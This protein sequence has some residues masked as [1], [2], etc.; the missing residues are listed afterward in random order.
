MT[1]IEDWEV[2]LVDLGSRLRI[3]RQRRRWSQRSF[4]E[5]MGVSKQ[6]VERLERGDP[7]IRLGTLA[8]A[9][10]VLSLPIEVLDELADPAHDAVGLSHD[11]SRTSRPSKIQS[12]EDE[13]D[14]GPRR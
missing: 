6:T 12:P 11:I 8:S 9:L 10:R 5:R 2:A 14:F 4:A 1:T 7:G 13:Y 3:A